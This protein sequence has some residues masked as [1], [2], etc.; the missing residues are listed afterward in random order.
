MACVHSYKV[1]GHNELPAVV[2]DDRR[3]YTVFRP[4]FQR[5]DR[6]SSVQKNTYLAGLIYIILISYRAEVRPGCDCTILIVIAQHRNGPVR[7]G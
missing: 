2:G 6:C 5:I 4:I 7:D 1:V 3:G